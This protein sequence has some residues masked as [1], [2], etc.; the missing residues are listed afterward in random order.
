MNLGNQIVNTL[1]YYQISYLLEDLNRELCKLPNVRKV[2]TSKDIKSSR[3]PSILILADVT[4]SERID[5]LS[6]AISLAIETERK[7]DKLTRSTDW[8]V[9]VFVPW[10][11]LIIK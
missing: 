10:S 2:V 9:Q 1:Y 5:L 3:N 11:K 4:P 6:E 8:D 7:L